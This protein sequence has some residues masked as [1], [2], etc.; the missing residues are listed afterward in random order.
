MHKIKMISKEAQ[1]ISNSEEP[2]TV[3]LEDFS[4]AALVW[5]AIIKG[6]SFLAAPV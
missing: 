1:K 3:H 4:I 2:E 5:S 6:K